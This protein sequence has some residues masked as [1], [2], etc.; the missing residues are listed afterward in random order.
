MIIIQVLISKFRTSG[1]AMKV[2][3]TGRPGTEKT[4]EIVACVSVC[5]AISR[6]PFRRAVALG[7]I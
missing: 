5:P 3:A 6:A 7:I 2:N 4:Q 1:S